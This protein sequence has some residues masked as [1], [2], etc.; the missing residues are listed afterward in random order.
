MCSSNNSGSH[1]TSSS[2]MLSRINW[3]VFVLL[4]IEKRIADNRYFSYIDPRCPKPT[5]TDRPFRIIPE[6]GPNQILTSDGDC[7]C[8]RGLVPDQNGRCVP[9]S[10]TTT[11]GN[12]HSLNSKLNITFLTQLISYRSNILTASFLPAHFHSWSTFWPMRLSATFNTTRKSMCCSHNQTS[13]NND[14]S[15]IV[16]TSIGFG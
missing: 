16:L 9:Q 2:K 1:N 8:E 7:I 14:Y 5:T 4:S 6:C 3:L 10:R 11:Q 12:C 13:Y 15:K